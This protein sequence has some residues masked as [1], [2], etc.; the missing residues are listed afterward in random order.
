MPG[1]PQRNSEIGIFFPGQKE[2]MLLI[3]LENSY[4]GCWNFS[5]YET[6]VHVYGPIV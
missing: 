4:T 2:F 1:L 6:D 3:T 5:L